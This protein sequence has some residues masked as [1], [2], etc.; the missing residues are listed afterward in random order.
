MKLRV[1]VGWIHYMV[2]L[3]SELLGSEDEI[4]S[5][6]SKNKDR[7]TGRIF[8]VSGEVFGRLGEIRDDLPLS[9]LGEEKATLL[10]HRWWLLAV[11]TALT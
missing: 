9:F 6:F 4:D 11:L 10:N 5:C 2:Y 3:G 7:M 8:I 1:A